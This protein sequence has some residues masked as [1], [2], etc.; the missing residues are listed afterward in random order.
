[1]AEKEGKARRQ[2][3]PW[4]ASMMPLAFIVIG[5]SAQ[6][7]NTVLIA[8]FGSAVG[9]VDAIEGLALRLMVV[10]WPLAVVG[11][12]L[13][14]R[15]G[16][17][18]GVQLRPARGSKWWHLARFGTGYSATGFIFEGTRILKEAKQ[19]LGTA[20][21]FTNGGGFVTTVLSLFDRRKPWKQRGQ[22]MIPATVG[23]GGMYIAVAAGLPASEYANPANALLLVGCILLGVLAL[24]QK[25]TMATEMGPRPADKQPGAE[26][27]LRALKVSTT[28]GLVG[29]IV[30][31]VV[32]VGMA[33]V[34]GVPHLSLR[35][36]LIGVALATCYAMSQVFIQAGH[37]FG[38][39]GITGPL[40]FLAV[41]FGYVLDELRGVPGFTLQH[42]LGTA[43]IIASAL[44]S[45]FLTMQRSR[46]ARAEGAPGS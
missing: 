30:S 20:T 4:F 7:G 35:A 38:D 40:M 31:S 14:W 32:F 8:D 3:P 1:M 21:L 2:L 46:Q 12:V 41:G 6:A 29:G 5:A 9:P 23:I 24:V 42:L 22:D 27:L 34:H 11:G 16:P 25:K 13:V 33:M 44:I 15:F 39:P 10:F 37:G 43:V 17:R 18:H 45:V 26:K 36:V 19:A 28:F